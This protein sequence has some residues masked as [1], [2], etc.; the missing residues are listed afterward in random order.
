MKIELL[1]NAFR[2][3]VGRDG[4]SAN[5]MASVPRK[6]RHLPVAGE[7][8]DGVNSGEMAREAAVVALAAETFDPRRITRNAAKALMELLYEAGR[9]DRADRDVIFV[10]LGFIGM[11]RY[12]F[13]DEH[14]GNLLAAVREH[15][16]ESG[17]EMRML[18]V[19]NELVALRTR[20][21]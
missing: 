4:L 21:A 2:G 19:L 20:A 5:D 3:V 8:Y 14:P 10:R 12:G 17:S 1:K 13:N 11:G 16:G 6:R 7:H 9:I 15:A 18:S